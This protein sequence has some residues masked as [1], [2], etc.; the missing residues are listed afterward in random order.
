MGI[1]TEITNID[2]SNNIAYVRVEINHW[3]GSLNND[4]IL[5]IKDSGGWKIIA[6]IY[7]DR[8]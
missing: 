2:V 8:G 7:H 3:H 4:M 1:E 5:L 6:K